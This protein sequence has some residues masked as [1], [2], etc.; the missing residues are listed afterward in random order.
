MPAG[1]GRDKFRFHFRPVPASTE[2]FNGLDWYI[3]A[4]ERVIITEISIAIRSKYVVYDVGKVKVMV[5]MG[6]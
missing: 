4:L 1:Y 3:R 2:I 5:A 6:R